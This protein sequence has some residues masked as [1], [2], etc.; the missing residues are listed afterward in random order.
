MSAFKGKTDIGREAAKCPL[1]GDLN[2]LPCR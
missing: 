1:M 2:L